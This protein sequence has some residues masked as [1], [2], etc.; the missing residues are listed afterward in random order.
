MYAQSVWPEYVTNECKAR[1]RPMEVRLECGQMT[2][3][4][5]RGQMTVRLERGQ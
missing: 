2:V 1:M 3:R 4:L 5:E